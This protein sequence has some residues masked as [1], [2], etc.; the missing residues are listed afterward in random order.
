MEQAIS[1]IKTRI[2]EACLR[3]GRNPDDVTLIAVTK[4]RSA[5]EIAA[6]VLANNHHILGES[7]IQEWRKKAAE[8]QHSEWH[9]IGNL[10]TNKVKY[11]EG[12]HSIHSLN[13][14]HLAA[15]LEQFGSKKNHT[16]RV[17]AEVNVT[18]EKSKQGAPLD[19]VTALVDA[20][21]KMAHLEVVGLMTIAPYEDDPEKVRG[22]FRELKAL[23]DR[24]E[25]P[26]LSMGMSGDFEVAIE[27]GATYVRVGTALFS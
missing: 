15:A 14:L 1:K 7:R 24:L 13:S 25:L 23:G 8:L 11:C 22:I 19:K 21:R 2:A 12:F 20:A 5:A 16:F 10:Q 3:A 27:E 26:E 6:A 17:F 4:G 18:G 9:F